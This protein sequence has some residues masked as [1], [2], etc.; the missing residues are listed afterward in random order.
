MDVDSE[1]C[2]HAHWKIP[3]VQSWLLPET[4]PL[5]RP[6]LLPVDS[7]LEHWKNVAQ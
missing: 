2:I 4:F 6:S 1:F 3:S 5:V 7:L